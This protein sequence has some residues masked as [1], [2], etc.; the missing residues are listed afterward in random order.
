MWHITIFPSSS[1]K[2]KSSFILHHI[3]VLEN[4]KIPFSCYPNFEESVRI[5][6]RYFCVGICHVHVLIII[7]IIF[8]T[9]NK[10]YLLEL[11]VKTAKIIIMQ[12]SN[13]PPSFI[14]TKHTRQACGAVGRIAGKQAYSRLPMPHESSSRSFVGTE[15]TE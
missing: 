1:N 8:R 4:N 11:N 6:N 9:A 12:M 13:L 3:F 10:Q 15:R 2:V 14:R 5:N 7:Y